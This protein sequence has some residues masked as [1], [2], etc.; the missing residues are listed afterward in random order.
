ME[1]AQ[2]MTTRQPPATSWMRRH[3]STRLFAFQKGQVWVLEIPDDRVQEPGGL[4]TVDKA[5]IERERQREYQAG[6]NLAVPNHRDFPD[7]A[8]SQNSHLRVVDDWGGVGAADR[9]VV[10]DGECAPM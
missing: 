6:D 2:T 3:S 4:R 9:P 10:G 8:H 7:A 5:V 1:V